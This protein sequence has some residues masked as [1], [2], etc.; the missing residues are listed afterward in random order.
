M[1]VLEDVDGFWADLF[2]VEQN[3]LMRLLIDYVNVYESGLEIKIKTSGMR[4][5]IKEI[6]NVQN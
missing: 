2:P 6:T 1:E 4:G 3:R 5:L